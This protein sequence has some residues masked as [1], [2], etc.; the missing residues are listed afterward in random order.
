MPAMEPAVARSFTRLTAL[1][2]L[3]FAGVYG[4]ITIVGGAARWGAPAYEVALQVPG[5]PQSWGAVLFGASVV[6]LLGFATG[7]LP[8]IMVGFALCAGWAT[9]FALCIGVVAARNESVG[10]GGVVTWAFLALLYAACTAAGG[11]RF[12]APAV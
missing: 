6:G 4:L 2:M 5:S 8:V 7:A 9:C 12:H 3:V 10:W 11:S 1:L